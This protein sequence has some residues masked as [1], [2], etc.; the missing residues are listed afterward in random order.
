MTVHAK[1]ADI[2]FRNP[3]GQTVV[4]VEVKNRQGLTRDV[5]ITLHRNLMAH[6][7]LPPVPYFLLVSQEF[8]Y[9]WKAPESGRP[10]AP[11]DFEF[12]MADVMRRYWPNADSQQRLRENE[13][14]LVVLQWL[15]DLSPSSLVTL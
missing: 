12:P 9:L 6:G 11:P 4:A 7:L 15:L 14:E 2:V 8:G 10:E 13:F 3:Y 5:A 1:E